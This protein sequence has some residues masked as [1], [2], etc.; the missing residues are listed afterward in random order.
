MTQ[1]LERAYTKLASRS[2]SEQNAIASL[3]LEA[4]EDDEHWD[5]QFAGSQSSLA[6]LAMEA[7]A[8]HRAG[9]TV[10]LDPQTI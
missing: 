4:L 3:M 8:E 6:K 2:E 5:R 7:L 9:K 1:L 10:P